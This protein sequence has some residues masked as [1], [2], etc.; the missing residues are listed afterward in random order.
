MKNCERGLLRAA[1]LSLLLGHALTAC[2]SGYYAQA[3]RGHADMRRRERPCEAVIADA[4]TSPQVKG[5]LELAGRLCDFADQKLGLP[6]DGQYSHYADLERRF[7]VWNVF[8][9]PEF[10]LEPH[11]WWY[12]FIGRAAYRGYFAEEKAKDCAKEMREK[13]NDVLVGGVAVYS[14][15]GFFRD[16]LLNTFIGY[17]EPMLA[18]TI[19]HEL[20]HQRVFAGGDSDFNEAFATAVGQEGA[21]RWLRAQGNMALLKRYEES[22]KRHSQIL[23]LFHKAR[24]KL[25]AVY[26][27]EVLPEGKFKSSSRARSLSDDELRKQKKMVLKEVKRDFRKLQAGWGLRGAYSRWVE[28]GLNNAH[29]SSV[30]TYYDLVPAFDRLMARVGGD[31]GKFYSEVEKLAKLPRE[32]RRRW[33]IAGE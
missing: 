24:L 26:G 17:S 12:P 8:A 29:L 25:A 1:V 4:G 16:P 28:E 5:K 7:V 27:D 14:T 9:T 23:S 20:A 3:L 11:T 31:L 6:A 30:S 13:G 10:S 33:L 19:F 18:E 32:E 2:Q 21:R 15:L 22:M